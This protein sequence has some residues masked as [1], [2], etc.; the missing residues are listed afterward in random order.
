LENSNNKK[1]QNPVSEQPKADKARAK[2]KRH[3]KIIIY[4][5]SALAF[6]FLVVFPVLLN[7]FADRIIG[8]TLS[9]IVRRESNQRYSLAFSSVSLNVFSN[10]ITLDSVSL[11]PDSAIVFSDQVPPPAYAKILIPKIYLQE[12]SW[13]SAIINRE[14]IIQDLVIDQAD[15]YL[16]LNKGYELQAADSTSTDSISS[17]NPAFAHKHLYEFIAPYLDFFILEHFHF[18]KAGLKVAIHKPDK[19]DTLILQNFSMAINNFQ[20]DSLAHTRSHRFFFS[21]S[22]GMNFKDGFFRYHSSGFEVSIGNMDLSSA[23]GKLRL[24]QL[25][26]VKFADTSSDKS[27]Q[28]FNADIGKLRMSGLDFVEILE[29]GNLRMDALEI[30]VPA[31]TFYEE[32]QKKTDSLDLN[33][34]SRQL[35]QVFAPQLKLLD[36]DT[37]KITQGSL[38]WPEKTTAGI[39]DLAIPNFD[40]TLTRLFID[41]ASLLQRSRFFFV[42]DFHF[43]S[44]HQFLDM[45]ASGLLIAYDTLSL[46]TATNSLRIAALDLRQKDSAATKDIH[47]FIP[48]LAVLS[49]DFK[50]DYLSKSL[51]LKEVEIAD[52][53]IRVWSKSKKNQKQKIDIYNLYPLISENLKWIEI[54]HLNVYRANI[55]LV[56]KSGRQ[57]PWVVDGSLDIE[58]AGFKLNENSKGKRRIFY[59]DSVKWNL[60]NVMADLPSMGYT[61]CADAV[62]INTGKASLQIQNMHVDTSLPKPA[63]AAERIN[64]GSLHLSR[65]AAFDF[66]YK[67]LYF[68]GNVFVGELVLD[69]PVLDLIVDNKMRKADTLPQEPAKF[70]Y[71]LGELK[72]N[73]GQLSLRDKML[74]LSLF[75][76]GHADVEIL[77]L[78]PSQRPGGQ[79]VDASDIEARL[80]GIVY[81]LPDNLQIFKMDQLK[82]SS[83][84]SLVE[85][86]NIDFKLNSKAD[87]EALNRMNINVPQLTIQG[88]PLFDLYHD[89]ILQ[90]GLVSINDPQIQ[91]LK[92]NQAKPP[93]SFHNFDAEIIKTLVLKS[94]DKINL[95]SIAITDADFNVGERGRSGQ[96]WVNAAGVDFAIQDFDLDKDSKMESGNLFY[97]SNIRFETDSLHFIPAS[98]KEQIIA[99]D[100]SISTAGQFF[101]MASLDM[102]AKTGSA[103]ATATKLHI[104]NISIQRLDYFKLIDEKKLEFALLEMDK[105]NLVLSP[106]KPN[107]QAKLDSIHH[108]NAYE[109]IKEHLYSISAGELRVDEARLK[110]PRNNAKHKNS[111]LFE[112]IDFDLKNI[113]IDSSNH[114]FE[115][116][117]LYSDDF[118][119]RL[120]HF[121]ENSYDSLYRFG[122]K[123]I[124]FSSKAAS[125]IVD[126]GYFKPN[127]PDSIFFAKVGVQTDILDLNFE[128]A[129]LNKLRLFDLIVD[130]TLWMD[131]LEIDSLEGS[132]FRSKEYPRPK[133][134]KP[135]MPATALQSLGFTLRVDTLNVNNSHFMYREFLPPAIQP[136]EIW[137]SNIQLEAFNITNSEEVITNTP[138]MVVDASAVM[139]DEGLL[140]LNLKFDIKNTNDYWTGKGEISQFDLTRLNPI[141]EHVAFVKVTKGINE[142]LTFDVKADIERATGE[143]KFRYEKLHIRLID[144][145]TLRT[146][147]FGESIASFIANTFVVRRSNPKFPFGLREGDIY[148]SRDTTRSFFNYL[149][150]SALSGVSSTIRGTNEE[151]KEKRQKRNME[152]ELRKTGRLDEKN[153]QKMQKAGEP[154]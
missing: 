36:I 132:D 107:S 110:I 154:E 35:L 69:R 66:D 43:K 45:P 53:K 49:V 114:L 72:I 121:T 94:F 149:T 62:D 54:D 112:D 28:D 125:L 118:C 58:L 38:R 83:A 96:A 42:D 82:L 68:G 78:S 130:N 63:R 32:T 116:K 24:K 103:K 123:E 17:D 153:K 90:A 15:I 77:N 128:K 144:K 97:A 71:R 141:L 55:D 70:D 56:H 9:E 95:D 13:I 138:T 151:R 25:N 39:I 115:N 137:F 48:G 99:R 47:I 37:V 52:A 79:S 86:K 73:D 92:S 5:L 22:L 81:R 87:N 26:M 8:S 147:G 91:Y 119:F 124:A 18:R 59:S 11:V 145:K 29:S 113:E 127:Y 34:L 44:Y 60:Q 75:T 23:D 2:K 67:S 64:L 61:L 106:G 100:I 46:N 140:G 84:D 4:T 109:L 122:A 120:H 104:G 41:S 40:L 3:R 27:Q 12:T 117:F 133:N 57:L 102:N 148:F 85:F 126:D 6:L 31:L 93:A 7:I 105:P 150:K 136:G 74:E 19:T 65:I 20:L 51:N 143:M 152:R 14:L 131:K 146:E 135:T 80:S 142:K 111:Y 98:G 129:K 101:N 21:D 108:F 88:L 10:N 30:E 1:Q 76:L 134:H 33:K 50:A 16:S 139:M 89:N